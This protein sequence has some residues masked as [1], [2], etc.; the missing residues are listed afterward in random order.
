MGYV[1]AHWSRRGN[2]IGW[3]AGEDASN[4][5]SGDY[6]PGL[7]DLLGLPFKRF[8]HFLCVNRRNS[9]NFNSK[10]TCITIFLNYINLSHP[11]FF[12]I[13][14]RMESPD[15]SSPIETVGIYAFYMA[16]VI[17]HKWLIVC[18]PVKMIW[19]IVRL[20]QDSEE[21]IILRNAPTKAKV[22]P[23]SNPSH[24]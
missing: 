7:V 13:L 24:L 23:K 4:C 1:I 3:L 8:T 2:L 11:S 9:I 16:S 6:Q 19:I 12:S 5:R 21:V 18:F 14:T 15:P 20:H 22:L 10:L 17:F